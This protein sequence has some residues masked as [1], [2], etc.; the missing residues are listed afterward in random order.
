L[1]SL[2][3]KVA[4]VTG[5][6]RGIGFAISKEFAESNSATVIVCSRNRQ[7]AVKAAEQIKGKVFAAKIDVTNSFNIKRFLR[8]ILSEHKRIDILVNNAGYPFDT[9][10]WYKNL[11]EVTDDEINRIIEV[12]LKGSFRLSKAIIH[13]CCKI[14]S[15]ME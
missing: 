9:K 13:S 8:K 14:L 2:R 15:R 1:S 12:D 4:V 10:I 5:S 11:H 6:S 7:Q 3:G